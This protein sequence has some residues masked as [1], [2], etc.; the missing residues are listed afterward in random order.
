MVHGKNP[1]PYRIDRSLT[2]LAGPDY[3]ATISFGLPFELGDCPYGK[4]RS[5]YGLFP[6]LAELTAMYPAQDWLAFITKTT[7]FCHLQSGNR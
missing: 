1:I 5:T 7:V 3:D 2:G 4:Y 6:R